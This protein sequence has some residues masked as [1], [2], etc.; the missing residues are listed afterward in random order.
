MFYGKPV[1]VTL[2]VDW[3][4]GFDHPSLWNW[5]MLVG[6]NTVLVGAKPS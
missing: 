2:M 6:L 1:V 3:E 4:E 5:E